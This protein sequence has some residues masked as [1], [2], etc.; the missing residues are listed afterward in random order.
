MEREPLICAWHNA[1]VV[2]GLEA[3]IENN[4]VNKLVFYYVP[5][6]LIKKKEIL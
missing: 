3:K 5:F 4:N 2:A 1:T 6:R